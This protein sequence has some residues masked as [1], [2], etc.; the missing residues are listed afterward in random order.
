[1]SLS[2]EDYLAKSRGVT[3]DVC[4]KLS[5]QCRRF[6]VHSNEKTYVF[7]W[8]HVNYST[9]SLDECEIII[10]LTQ[11]VIEIIGCKLK[12]IHDAIM[13]DSLEFIRIIPR[14][15]LSVEATQGTV[16]Q[17]I[18]IQERAALNTPRKAK[19]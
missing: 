7:P 19:S 11:H 17:S 2:L 12:P 13:Q 8:M 16:V 6:K 3:P 10:Y 15:L 9:L 1:M 4:F 5:S 14:E 18:S